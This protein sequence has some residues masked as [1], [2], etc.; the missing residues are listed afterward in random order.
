MSSCL[1]L[2][3]GAV[4]W[5]WLSAGAAPAGSLVEFP[6]VSDQAKPAHLPGYLARPNGEGPFPAV[7]VLHGCTGF[8]GSYATIADRLAWWGYAVL[9]VDS[10]GPRGIADHCGGP[11]IEQAIDSYAALNYLS[12]Q[13]FVDPARVAVLGFSM[14]GGSVL[15]AVEHEAIN[16]LFPGKFAAAIAYYP[17]CRGRS[18]L[19]D[20]P[21]I[22]LIGEADD[23][24]PAAGCREMVAQPHADSAPIELIVYPGAHHGFNFATLK[25]GSSSFGHRLEYNEPAAQ[26]AEAKVRDFL[27]LHLAGAS[28]GAPA[29][30]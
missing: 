23:W 18:A 27:A 10:L 19:V 12:R 28:L 3:L 13:P 30:R 15:D 24:T 11:F 29:V 16:R 1:R 2:L 5:S 26:D 17:W 20:T 7:V 22:I 14:G 9:A 21:T 4:L 6:N 25:P 8:F